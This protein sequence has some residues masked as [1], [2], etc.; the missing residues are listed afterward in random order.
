MLTKKWTLG[1]EELIKI[2]MTGIF[3]AL[4]NHLSDC[5]GFNKKYRFFL[6][7]LNG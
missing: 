4:L 3:S 6:V 5:V 7:I 2:I 1:K